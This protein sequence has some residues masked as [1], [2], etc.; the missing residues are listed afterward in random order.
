MFETRSPMPMLHSKDLLSAP[1]PPQFNVFFYHYYGAVS[2]R[3]AAMG[4]N[5]GTTSE[6]VLSEAWFTQTDTVFKFNE[7][8]RD[9]YA[10][11]KPR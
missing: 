5:L 3:C 9:Q 4:N 11:G 6:V 1:P 8:L 10:P 2:Q 7:L